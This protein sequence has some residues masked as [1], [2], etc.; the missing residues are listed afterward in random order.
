MHQRHYENKTDGTCRDHSNH[1][2]NKIDGIYYGLTTIVCIYVYFSFENFGKVLTTSYRKP[3]KY[4]TNGMEF[5]LCA[6]N[7]NIIL[8]WWINKAQNQTQSIAHFHGSNT[9]IKKNN[10]T[11]IFR[12]AFVCVR[13]YIKGM[14][15]FINIRCGRNSQP[16]TDYSWTPSLLWYKRHQFHISCAY[17]NCCIL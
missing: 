6:H 11:K 4:V 12:S 14:R 9:N 1:S 16:N 17:C 3:K 8:L 2:L 13:V 15:R 7:D 10:T 5:L